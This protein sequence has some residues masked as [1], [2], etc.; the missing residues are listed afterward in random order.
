[1][2]HPI[3]HAHNL[4]ELMHVFLILGLSRAST[5]LLARGL[6]YE[7]IPLVVRLH[8]LPRLSSKPLTRTRTRI[9]AFPTMNSLTHIFLKFEHEMNSLAHSSQIRVPPVN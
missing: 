3:S 4:Y 5:N 6:T 2:K 8:G 9:P 1:M 7:H